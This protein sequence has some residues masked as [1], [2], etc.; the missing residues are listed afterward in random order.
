MVVTYGFEDV[1]FFVIVMVAFE[2]FVSTTDA[3]Q[4]P[5]E[6]VLAASTSERT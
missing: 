3:V 5:S 4:E 1:L 2:T 6:L